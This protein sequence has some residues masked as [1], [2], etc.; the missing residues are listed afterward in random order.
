MNIESDLGIDSIK[1]VEILSTLEEKI[2]GLPAISPEIMGSM[3]TLGQIVEHLSAI[4][5]SDVHSVPETQP[6]NWL[7]NRNAGHGHEYRVRPWYRFH[8]KG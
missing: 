7:S 2:P 5:D 4:P 1:R 6:A 8:K 3:K